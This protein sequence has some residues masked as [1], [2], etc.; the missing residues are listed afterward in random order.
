MP[1]NLIEAIRILAE[2][3]GFTNPDHQARF[4]AAL[5]VKPPAATDNPPVTAGGN[6]APLTIAEQEAQANANA[7]S[8]PVNP[9]PVEDEPKTTEE[10]SV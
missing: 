7:T 1:E 6:P 5:G 4:E 2:R 3:V 9:S 8:T 10:S